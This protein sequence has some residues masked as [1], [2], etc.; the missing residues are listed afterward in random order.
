MTE[1]N[2]ET[3]K[4]EIKGV[5][6][7]NSVSCGLERDK[8]YEPKPVDLIGIVPTVGK[9]A[10]NPDKV[11][12][13]NEYEKMKIELAKLRTQEF[14]NAGT[15]DALSYKK[16]HDK[17]ELM[18]EA[19]AIREGERRGYERGKRQRTEDIGILITRVSD[20]VT[21]NTFAIDA[22]KE[23]RIAIDQ[24]RNKGV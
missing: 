5:G 4:F 17:Y 1:R 14:N 10:D 11:G 3:C 19:Q 6:C 2:C 23:L 20:T 12:Y 15:M 7:L 18:F 9:S 8:F 16:I 13:E 24:L 22:L 21:D